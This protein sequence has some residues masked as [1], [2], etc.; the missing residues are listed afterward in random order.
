MI[1]D[2]SC[3]CQEHFNSYDVSQSH[4]EDNSYGQSLV[5]SGYYGSVNND[6]VLG[7]NECI[8]PDHGN[9]TITLTKGTIIEG[10]FITDT[11]TE[12]YLRTLTTQVGLYNCQVFN[13]WAAVYANPLCVNLPD[14]PPTDIHDISGSE[15]LQGLSGPNPNNNTVL[16]SPL[17]QK[18]TCGRNYIWVVKYA[19]GAYKGKGEGNLRFELNKTS[20]NGTFT[21][22]TTREL[23][24]D[25]RKWHS[26][27]SSL[28]TQ[29][30]IPSLGEGPLL[31]NCS[32]FYNNLP[33]T[34]MGHI[35]SGYINNLTGPE[36]HFRNI[37]YAS[38]FF[39]GIGDRCA[40]YSVFKTPRTGNDYQASLLPW[41]PAGLIEQEKSSFFGMMFGSNQTVNSSCSVDLPVIPT[42]C[43]C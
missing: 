15:I 24:Q 29:L 41:S 42:N 11:F 31:L 30:L 34:S 17:L 40:P 6:G 36:K 23:F 13:F 8:D 43:I 32:N 7:N 37:M 5:A 38:T 33:T 16:W 9:N 1:K 4:D 19:D 27:L 21:R 10:E 26:Q 20:E 18:A 3:S 12:A 39:I 2:L 14:Q 22:A 28:P 25:M 35:T